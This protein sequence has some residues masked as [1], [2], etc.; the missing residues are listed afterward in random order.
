MR[1]LLKVLQSRIFFVAIAVIL[2][3]IW[4]VSIF[5]TLQT[6][7]G[8]ASTT[9][10]AVGICFAISVLNK[11][12]VNSSYKLAWT[13][14]ILAVPLIGIVLYLLFG[15]RPASA[16]RQR[17]SDCSHK[18]YGDLQQDKE[19]VEKLSRKSKLAASN[20]VYLWDQLKYPVCEHTQTKYFAS[21]EDA[22]PLMLD[23]IRN[24]KRYI[25]LEFFIVEEGK[26]WNEIL[27]LLIQKQLEGVEV[28]VMY[29]DVGSANTVPVRYRQKLES[30]G[31]ACRK[32][33]PMHLILSIILNYRDHRKI[34]VVDGQTAFTGG[35]NLADEYINEKERFGYWKDAVIRMEGEAAY[36]LTNMFLEMWN[37]TG[38]TRED[39]TV[40]KP[41]A[42][43]TET[44]NDGFVQAYED[45]PFRLEPVAETLYIHLIN[46][47]TDYVYI[48]TPYFLVDDT[49]AHAIIQAAQRGVDVRIMM[50]GIPDKKLVFEMAKASYVTMVEHGVKF[51]HYKPGF[52]HSKCLVA[53]DR[54]ATIGTVNFDFRSL[55]LHFENG[56]YLYDARAVMELKE[57]FL[58]TLRVCEPVTIESCYKKPY[59]FRVFLAVMKVFA[60]L[61]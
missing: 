39:Y 28:R 30:Y 57:D 21:G 13:V 25:F 46:Q 48:M 43:V 36:S 9:L 47:A 35:I 8:I 18:V 4:I 55:F 49:L 51:Y 60:P 61:L 54:S 52:V 53:D 58:H 3:F 31:I 19:V 41:L 5:Y 27:D 56:M 15:T 14:A 45:G 26:M 2:Q 24:A 40:Y 59:A 44:E 22:F 7:F 42:K 6:R 11:S 32:F 29:D 17:M 20:T 10:H 37:Y 12:Q 34:L 16:N 38:N 50:P 23:V 1:Q 33:H